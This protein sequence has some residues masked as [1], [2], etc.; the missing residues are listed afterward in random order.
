MTRKPKRDIEYVGKVEKAIS[1]KYGQEAV[2][3]PR[4]LWDEEKEKEYREQVKEN[5]EK[6]YKKDEDNDVIE[7][8]G[9]FISKKLLN[10]RNSS[11]CDVCSKY[12]LDIQ[13]NVFMAKWG[14][15]QGCYVKWV[16]DRED[17]WLSGWRPEKE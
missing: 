17:R 16:E 14:C 9:I 13:D 2:V 5:A 15:C 7:N 11:S 6:Y 8:N 10:K 1:D 4:L 3:N 12:M